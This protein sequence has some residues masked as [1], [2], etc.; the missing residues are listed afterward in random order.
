MN[1]VSVGMDFSC[2]LTICENEERGGLVKRAK[3]MGPDSGGSVSDRGL[4]FKEISLLGI[5]INHLPLND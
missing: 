1:K 3:G 2:I 5:K 4:I